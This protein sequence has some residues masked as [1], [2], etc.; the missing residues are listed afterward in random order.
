MRAV[1]LVLLG[2][3]AVTG[4]DDPG[5]WRPRPWQ[6]R[7]AALARCGA[8]GEC[9]D[10]TTCSGGNGFC[11]PDLDAAGECPQGFAA[12]PQLGCF[13]V[14]LPCSTADQCPHTGACVDGFCIIPC[15]SLEDPGC[16]PGFTCQVSR[17][18]CVL[19]RACASDGDCPVQE[20]CSARHGRCYPRCKGACSPGAWCAAREGLCYPDRIPCRSDRFC[21]APLRCSPSTRLC[22]ATCGDGRP[23]PKMQECVVRQG[24][25]VDEPR[26]CARDRDCAPGGGCFKQDRRCYLRCSGEE[27]CPEGTSCNEGFCR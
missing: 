22:A 25:C 3:M 26:E 18:S 2:S 11:L 4:C 23:C 27:A 1:L 10:R 9:P 17:R 14:L 7:P 15:F 24:L 6:G 12:R 21:P 5:R 20:G 8:G 13:P 19:P 16:P